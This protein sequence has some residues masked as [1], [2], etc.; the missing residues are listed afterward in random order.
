MNLLCHLGLYYSVWDFVCMWRNLGTPVYP[1]SDTA[2]M[3]IFYISTKSRRCNYD[4][5]SEPVEESRT[6][7]EPVQESSK[8]GELALCCTWFGSNSYV[9]VPSSITMRVNLIRFLL[10][11]MGPVSLI[12]D[13][14]VYL[15][16]NFQ[17]ILL[18][19]HWPDLNDVVQ[20]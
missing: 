1:C 20:I 16:R 14:V 12:H 18:Q 8:H 17:N 13:F 19:N 5:K 11:G 2:V 15:Y 10:H 3:R 9:P 6:I 4:D 7:Q